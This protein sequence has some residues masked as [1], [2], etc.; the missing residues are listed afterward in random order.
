M[1]AA[2]MGVWRL[3]DTNHDMFEHFHEQGGTN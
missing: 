1:D 3:V 2:R